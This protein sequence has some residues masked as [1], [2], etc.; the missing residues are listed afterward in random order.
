M[1]V[2]FRMS[3]TPG[4]LRIP[5]PGLAEHTDD[6]LRELGKSAEEIARLKQVGACG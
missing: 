1:N 5:P 3:E 6:V 4:S 2:L